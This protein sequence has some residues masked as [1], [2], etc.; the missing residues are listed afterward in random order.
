[1]RLL[2]LLMMLFLATPAQAGPWPRD[3]GETFVALSQR[4]SGDPVL[5]FTGRAR[6]GST[7][8]LYAEHGLT[9]RLTFVLDGGYDQGTGRMDVTVALRR[10]LTLGAHKLAVTA[11]AGAEGPAWEARGLIGAHWG[12]GFALG[13]RRGWVAA[14]AA[15]LW[16]QTSGVAVKADLT[17]GLALSEAWSILLQANWGEYSGGGDHLR[18]GPGLIW[19]VDDRRRLALSVDKDLMRQDAYGITLGVWQ[20]F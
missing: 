6:P 20:T 2:A 12:R 10:G 15:A 3:K 9:P 4:L 18:V 7:A 14:D 13:N 16:R 8:M 19:A 5:V 17:V 1:M 11:G